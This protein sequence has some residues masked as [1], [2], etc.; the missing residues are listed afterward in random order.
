MKYS[1]TVRTS[2]KML[3]WHYAHTYCTSKGNKTKQISQ[4]DAKDIFQKNFDLD[5]LIFYFPPQNHSLMPIT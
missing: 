1:K 5:S 4:R 3:T 2:K